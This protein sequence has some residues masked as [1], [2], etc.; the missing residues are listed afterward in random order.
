MLI[1]MFNNYDIYRI[2][3][4]CA[5]QFT[6]HLLIDVLKG[7]VETVYPNLKDF[8]NPWHWHLFQIDQFLHVSVMYV[9]SIL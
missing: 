6:S 8:T 3:F 2:L 1:L 5:L 9:I 4:L 7:T